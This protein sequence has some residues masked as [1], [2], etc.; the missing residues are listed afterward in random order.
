MYETRHEA[1]AETDGCC[2]GFLAKEGREARRAPAGVLLADG[3]RGPHCE[4]IGACGRMEPYA[5][6]VETL[7]GN[8]TGILADWPRPV[9]VVGYVFIALCITGVVPMAAAALVIWVIDALGCAWVVPVGIVAACA[10]G[11]RRCGP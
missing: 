10:Y 1:K 5:G 3:A 8:D 11:Y 7:G 2:G 4:E 9:R 6:S